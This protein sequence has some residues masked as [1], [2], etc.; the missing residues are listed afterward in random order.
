MLPNLSL[1]MKFLGNF[2]SNFIFENFLSHEAL[3][4]ER[5]TATSTNQTQL[6][7]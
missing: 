1:V 5:V 6:F 7:K 3:V 4:T 2:F